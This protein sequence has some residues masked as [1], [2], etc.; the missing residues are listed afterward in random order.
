MELN[1]PG[2]VIGDIFF[3]LC[4]LGIIVFFIVV[5]YFVFLG[6]IKDYHELHAKIKF[7][8]TANELSPEIINK[9]IQLL[10]DK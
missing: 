4:L 3:L 2:S 8:K 9:A 7:Y 10:S 6:L 5:I 1:K